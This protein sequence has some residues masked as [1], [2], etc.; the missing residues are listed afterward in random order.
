M[1]EK[2]GWVECC[3]LSAFRDAGFGEQQ[4][5]D[6]ILGI[7][8]KTLSNY[9]NH[10]AGTPVDEAFQNERWTAPDTPAKRA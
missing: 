5:L 3:D 8:L 9:T 1:L 4:V 7:G 2:R 6:L 10:I